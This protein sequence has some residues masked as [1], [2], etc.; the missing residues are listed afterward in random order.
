M[1]RDL[2]ISNGKLL[3]NFDDRYRLRDI[4]WPFVGQENHTAGHTCRTGIS[5]DGRFSWLDE[6]NWQITQ[7]YEENTLV[8]KTV[9]INTSLEIQLIFRDFVD[10]HE[11]IFIRKVI[12]KNLSSSPRDVE[13]FFHNDLHIMGTDIGNTAYYEPERKAVFHYKGKNWVVIN[14]AVGDKDLISIGIDQWAVGLKESGD[15]QGTW[16]DA[17]DGFL[18]KNPIA[19]GS[20]DSVVSGAY[21]VETMQ[22]CWYWF[23]FG[24]DFE[25]VARLNRL[26]R[27]KH[28]H[29]F[30]DRTR[31]YWK[32]WV[33]QARINE[34]PLPKHVED[35]YMRSLLIIKTQ[36]D[37]S[38]AILAATDYDLTQFNSDTYAYM[39]PR[40]GALVA[41]ALIEAGYADITRKFFDFCHRVITKEGYLLHKFN[42]DG[43]LASSWHSWF[44]D[45]E[46]SLPIQEDETA[47]VIWALRKHYEK[48]R[49]LDFIKDHYRG[50]VV[51]AAN[52]IC[53]YINKETNLPLPSWDLWE[54][55]RGI[56]AW[57]ISAVW[58]GLQAA[59]KFAHDFGE[60]DLAKKYSLTAQK[61]KTSF[62][63]LFWS[64]KENRYLC[65]LIN[66]KKENHKFHHPIDA[67]LSALWMFGMISA[68]DPRM[69]QTMDAISSQLAV[70]TPVGGIA[71]Y[72]D[73]PYYQTSKELSSIPG[74]PW[75]ISTLW[76][77]QW[78]IQTAK[79]KED[80][81]K[82]ISFL[83]WAY[84]N[85][86]LSGVMAEQI[87]PIEGVPISAS[88]LTWSHATFASTIQQ[89]NQK[90]KEF[91]N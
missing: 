26:V 14:F 84:K 49:D 75:F 7:N 11:D 53:S 47:L 59:A 24:E 48:F 82:A 10:F 65:S 81:D 31:N 46:K 44:I 52:W 77:G 37:N 43:S 51:R 64:K 86:L 2:P 67:S 19:Q 76:L 39:W 54:E 60:T 25:E 9:L 91:E 23:G 66:I 85:A 17:E 6:V 63:N 12:T 90:Y 8:T 69:I 38:G 79:T 5:I 83:E 21:K 70:K 78:Y 35:L 56:H 62:E 71:R 32:L 15:K 30:L 22:T 87:H 20:V 68:D 41:S 40:D 45:G 1:A 13:L 50:L 74:N 72:Y 18:S 58:A 36:V 3:V 34:F 80:L 16:K 61:M 89:Y 88:P 4:Y 55:R 42:P 29:T 33:E 28:P 27:E 57:T 73:D